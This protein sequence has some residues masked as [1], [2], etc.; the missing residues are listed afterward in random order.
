M[1]AH[2]AVLLLLGLLA[3]QVEP[4][5]AKMMKHR[6]QGVYHH[7]AGEIHMDEETFQTPA[8]STNGSP[9]PGMCPATITRHHLGAAYCSEGKPCPGDQKCCRVGNILKC[10]LPEG[11][12]RG[13]CPHSEDHA[14]AA[15]ASSSSSPCSDDSQCT[16]EE[17]CC[18]RGGLR[19]CTK[20]QP[21]KRG[22]CPKS[23]LLPAFRLC[24]S[25]CKDDRSCSLGLKCCFKDCGLKCVNPEIHHQ[26]SGQRNR[27]LWEREKAE[28]SGHGGQE[29]VRPGQCPVPHGSG[30]CAELC[31]SDASCPLGQKCCSNGC[32]HECMKVTGVKPGICPALARGNESLPLQFCSTDVSCPGDQLCCKTMCGRQ[33]LLPFGEHPGMCPRKKV[34]R[35]FAP[36]ED[37]CRDDRDCDITKKC[38]F[39]GCGR[40]CLDPVPSDRCLLPPEIGLCR[41]YIQL[42]FY[43]PVR[44]RCLQFL[45]GGCGGNSNRFSTKEECQKSC[46]K[47]KAGADEELLMELASHSVPDFCNLPSD[48]GHCD[49]STLRFHHSSHT[50]Q[51]LKFLYRG[52]GGNRNNFGTQLS[53]LQTC[54]DPGSRIYEDV[55]QEA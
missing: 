29:E 2:L 10:V 43:C 15:A 52:C 53:C 40:D 17:K 47:I 48:P 49:N 39:S 6:A 31:H 50:G 33:C 44:R 45:Y 25:E 1:R 23:R 16:S 27:Q 54:A 35:S 8:R 22:L 26:G 46:G 38:C 5:S 24:D 9:T 41:A 55:D 18:M 28:P 34:V 11:V 36:C 32:G 13:Y 30:T 3:L 12:H 14:A 51:C 19:R 7:E 42:Y 21:E 20:A 37:K 4:S